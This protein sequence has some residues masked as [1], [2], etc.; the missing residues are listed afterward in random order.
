MVALQKAN[1]GIITQPTDST[2]RYILKR[3]ENR[4]LNTDLDSMVH[5]TIIHYSPKVKIFQVPINR[6]VAKRMWYIHKMEYYSAM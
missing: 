2:P 1:Q 4:S 6:Q 3:T 5:C